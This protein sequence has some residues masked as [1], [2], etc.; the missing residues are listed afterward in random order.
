[1]LAMLTTALVPAAAWA[2]GHAWTKR[3]RGSR[4]PAASHR[5]EPV[6]DRA[7]S[8]IVG[9]HFARNGQF[10]W[11]AKVVARGGKRLDL[12]TGTVVAANLILTAGHC[13]E[14][15]QT[16]IPREASDY[17]VE[18]AADFARQRTSKPSRVSR[19]LV[20]PGF[21]PKSGVGDAALLELSTPTTVPPIRLASEADDWPAGT[22]ALMTGWGR[23]D[24]ARRRTDP[25]FLR[26]ATTVV[27]SSE[28]CAAH[29]RGFH[30]RRQLCS[31]NAPRD[32]TAGCSGDSGGPLLVKRATETIQIGVL[33]GSVM[34]RSKLVRC[35]TTQPTVYANSSLI[36]R[37]VHEW[38]ERL[39]SVPITITEAAP[40]AQSSTGSASRARTP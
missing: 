12:C 32:N 7:Y 21:E 39:T 13:A 9:G 3:H 1:M 2:D 31:M 35:L 23:T 17:E 27:Q 24:G 11:V 38:I 25:R 29:L 34:R 20:Y 4:A 8:A 36:S 15:V 5:V 19:V 40:A 30:V 22:H 37:W 14:D 26:W 18:T 28:W 6:H 33:N 10:P 16:G